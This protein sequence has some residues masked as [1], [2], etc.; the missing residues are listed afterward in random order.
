M[1]GAWSRWRAPGRGSAAWAERAGR[2]TGA[3][4]TF[5]WH[6]A[7]YAAGACLLIGANWLTGGS[8]WAFWPL[9]AWGVA[10]GAH[11]LFHKART[12]D[13]NWAEVRAADL[14]SK[15]YDA[16]HIDTIAGE[17]RAKDAA[18]KRDGTQA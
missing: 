9:A 8:W 16:S 1:R 13:E 11:F 4:R 2:A 7:L 3:A 14:R 18:G 6:A 17:S 15:S 5:R 12:V 10:L